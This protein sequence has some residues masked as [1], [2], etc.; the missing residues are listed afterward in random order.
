MRKCEKGLDDA[1][2]V[3]IPGCGDADEEAS[4]ADDGKTIADKCACYQE[5]TDRI[6]KNSEVDQ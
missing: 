1:Y 4:H 5:D 3:P 2:D 6:Q